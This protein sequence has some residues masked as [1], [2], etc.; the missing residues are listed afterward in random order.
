MYLEVLPVGHE[1]VIKKLS[2]Y[3]FISNFYLSGGTALALQIGH[4]ESVD[5]D[6]FSQ[7]DFDPE[8]IL[9]ILK[10]DFA[11]EDLAIAQG[12]LNCSINGIKLQFLCYPY[13]LLQNFIDWNRI[14]LSSIID[15]ACTKMITVSSRGSKKDYIDIFFLLKQYTLEEVFEA[16]NKKYKNIDFNKVHILKSLTSFEEADSQPTPRM[17]ETINW[18]IIKKTL[19]FK[20]TEFLKNVGV[21]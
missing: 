18:N 21:H 2:S 6:F 4:R 12:T 11:I 20:S 7:S 17:H 13:N 15:I 8:E 14:N 10:R 3:P 16:M 19:L 9:S 5:F 1:K